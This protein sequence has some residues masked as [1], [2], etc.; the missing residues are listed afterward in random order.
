MDAAREYFPDLATDIPVPYAIY[1]LIFDPAHEVIVDTVYLFVNDEYCQMA[2][3]RR[4]DLV[5]HRFL[6]I[7]PSGS[8]WLRYGQMVWEKKEP[9]HGCFFSEETGHWL[10]FTVGL[11]VG[12][13]RVAFVFTNVDA[14]IHRVR[15]ETTTDNAILK[16]TKL[17]NNDEDYRTSIDHAL[18]ELSRF[19]HPDRIYVLETDGRTVSNTFEWCAPGVEPEID[20]LQKLDY[21]DYIGGWENYLERDSQ[22]LIRDIEELKREDPVDYE[23]LKRQGIHRLVAAPFYNRGH[24]IGYLGADNYNS[25]DLINTQ[26]VLQS[27]SYFIGAKIVNQRLMED[28]NRLSHIDTLTNVHNRNAM[29]EKIDALSVKHNPVGLIYSDVNGLKVINDKHGHEA[30]DRALKFSAELLV[31]YFGREHVYRA[32]GDEFVVIY[33]N[34]DQ[35]EFLERQ[36]NLQAELKKSDIYHFSFGS[37]YC[38]DSAKIEKAIRIADRHMYNDKKK[39]Y[40]RMGFERRNCNDN[41]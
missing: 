23:N 13:D 31:R 26:L 28:L 18:A 4:E 10:D 40:L 9:F 24:L 17:L 37:F 34:I 36:K 30:G 11:A 2:G 19:I 16:I 35:D 20:T 5:N 8:R 41:L 39:Y 33:P 12:E 7:Y 14:F 15:R 3:Y 21:Q 22:V 6:E 1:K 25:D 29:I 38:K 27:I 32:G